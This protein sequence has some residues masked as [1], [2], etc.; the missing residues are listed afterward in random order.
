[1]PDGI[2]VVVIDDHGMVAE[3]LKATLSE[4]EGISVIGLASSGREGIDL[5]VS[6]RPNVVL[7]DFRLPDMT[8]A[9]VIRALTEKIPES[10]CVVLT[11]SG[12]DRALLE[13]L[14]AGAL[15]FLTK[16]QRFSEVVAAVRSAAVG[17]AS[18]SPALL[19]RVLPQL[20]NSTD[21][22]NRL[23]P[24][25]REILEQMAAGK[26]NGEIAEALF[27]SVNTVRNHVANV[28]TK[29]GAR[30]RVEAVAIATREGLVTPGGAET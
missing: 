27:V 30:T 29:L 9:D 1:M 14:E 10:R 16:H 15:G 4:Q 6:L 26:P 22:G 11:G 8:G 20:R 2:T 3:T 28:L 23:T 25:E 21:T 5:A 13:S 18:V 17:E 7:V 12:Q 19:G 24:R